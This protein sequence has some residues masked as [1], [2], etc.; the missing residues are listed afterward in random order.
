MVKI[1]YILPEGHITLSEGMILRK[2]LCFKIAIG[3]WGEGNEEAQQ[4]QSL[5]FLSVSLIRT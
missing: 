3:L 1:T 4:V 5:E 2:F